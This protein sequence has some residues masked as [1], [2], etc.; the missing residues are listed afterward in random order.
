M[1]GETVGHFPLEEIGIH[2]LFTARH[3]LD[4]I[5]RSLGWAGEKETAWGA[6]SRLVHEIERDLDR[7][8]GFDG[9]DNKVTRTTVLR[10]QII[11]ADLFK[12]DPDV[13]FRIAVL[14]GVAYSQPR[15]TPSSSSNGAK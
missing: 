11:A 9:R 15:F 14:W 1:A 13:A 12:K 10:D 5:F 3:E 8:P 6:V 2:G 7:D 4:Q